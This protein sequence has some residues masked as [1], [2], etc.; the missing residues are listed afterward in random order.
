[1]VLLK[2][3]VG[4]PPPYAYTPFGLPDAVREGVQGGVV[5]RGAEVAAVE[6]VLAD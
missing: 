4:N 6:R 5:V 1:L 2:V 3:E